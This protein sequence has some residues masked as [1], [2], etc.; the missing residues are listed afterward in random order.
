MA[1]GERL[2]ALVRPGPVGPLRA[3]AR[4]LARRMVRLQARGVPEYRA[5]DAAELARI[6]RDLAALDMPC[7]D[8]RLDPAAFRAFCARMPFP[9]DYHGGIDGGVHDEKRLEHFVAWHLLGLERGEAGPYVDIAA[10][11]SPWAKLLRERGLEAY[12]ID[13]EIGGDY[14]A[15]PYYLQRDATRSGFADAS[16]GAASL[17]CAYE[18]FVGAHDTELVAELGRV[19]R[20]GGRAVISP[21]YMHTHACRYQ[22]PEYLARFPGDPGATTYVRRDIWGV[23][24]SRKYSARTLRERVWDPAL[25]AGLVPTLHVLRNGAELGEGI[26]L[27]FVLVLDQPAVER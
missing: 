17:Q 10:C 18:M 3:L 13:L 5:P 23:P 16:I 22:T 26:Y 15:L 1:A 25:A 21:L 19:L 12:A 7:A 6:E 20:P 24:S 11:A 4:Y 2:H 9:A 27:H 8:L 14:A